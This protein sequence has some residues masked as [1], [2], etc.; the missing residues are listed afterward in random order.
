MMLLPTAA[1]YRTKCLRE[2]L[3]LS[4]G[5]GTQILRSGARPATTEP[6]RRMGLTTANAYRPQSMPAT[7]AFSQPSILRS[8]EDGE[9][10]AWARAV[11]RFP[12]SSETVTDSQRLRLGC[13]DS[14]RLARRLTR[15]SVHE[16][17]CSSS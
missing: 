4:A 16:R 7:S 14:T 13:A 3:N 1:R 15:S 9:T 2:T 11:E 5:L 17:G 6:Q 10:A 12:E 8:I